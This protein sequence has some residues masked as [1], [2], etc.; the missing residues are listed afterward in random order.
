MKG[1]AS[2]LSYAHWTRS[3]APERVASARLR[4]FLEPAAKE[5]AVESSTV[6][7]QA[8]ESNGSSP[9]TVSLPALGG[10]GPR[11][12]LVGTIGEEWPPRVVAM[13][14]DV[15]QAS[16]EHWRAEIDATDDVIAAAAYTEDLSS[17]EWDIALLSVMSQ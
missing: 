2:R 8:K 7:H 13:T 15:S 4:L 12:V 6:L 3:G 17:G 1:R 10:S 5:P 11:R 9:A 16:H 14:R